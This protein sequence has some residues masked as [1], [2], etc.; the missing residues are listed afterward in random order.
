[1]LQVQHRAGP[2]WLMTDF[3]CDVPVVE[4]S[5]IKVYAQVIK[6]GIPFLPTRQQPKCLPWD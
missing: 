4:T 5:Q 3:E 1:M 6:I 2:S